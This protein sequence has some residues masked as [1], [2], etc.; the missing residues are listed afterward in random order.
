[1]G[2]SMRR[3]IN[4]PSF[5]RGLPSWRLGKVYVAVGTGDELL[6]GLRGMVRCRE[7]DGMSS[8]WSEEGLG[9]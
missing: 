3:W 9:A 4:V 8:L 1:M 7:R 2:L 6:R 5:G